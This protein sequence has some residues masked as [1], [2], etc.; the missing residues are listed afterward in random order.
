MHALGLWSCSD[1]TWIWEGRRK[2]SRHSGPSFSCNFSSG[3]PE[4]GLTL[5]SSFVADS[6]H[7]AQEHLLDILRQ[8]VPEKGPVECTSQPVLLKLLYDRRGQVPG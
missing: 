5:L 1:P 4:D 6:D 7:E 3:A 2:A 8:N